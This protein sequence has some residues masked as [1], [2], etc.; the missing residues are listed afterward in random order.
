MALIEEFTLNEQA[1]DMERIK[2][3]N[4]GIRFL[5]ELCLLVIFG[6]WGFRTGENGL[7]RILLGLGTPIL[8]AVVWA[9]LLAPNSATRLH[10]PWLFLLENAI[11]GLAIW[12]LYHTGRIS[13][14]VAFS[15]IYILN[16][17][18]MMIWRQ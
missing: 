17:I 15:A 12:A 7:M 11:F 5:L 3:V 8:T 14:A 13:L 6:Y 10:Q 16:K 9:M 18:L 2:L 1:V 4:L